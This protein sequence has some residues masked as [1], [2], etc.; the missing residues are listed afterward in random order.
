MAK[1]EGSTTPLHELP[2][3][4]TV[5]AWLQRELGCD[6]SDR[7]EASLALIHYRKALEG[8]AAAVEHARSKR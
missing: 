1:P 8:I 4:E 7:L 3:V 5:T 6:L 2:S